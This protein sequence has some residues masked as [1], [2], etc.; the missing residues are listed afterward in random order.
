MLT[1][2]LWWAALLLL[3]LNDHVLKGAGLLDPSITGKLSDVVGLFLAP[4]LFA[5]LLRQ[6][7]RRGLLLT[8]LAIGAAFAAIN[9]SEHAANGLVASMG[10]LGIH[11][12]IWSDPT[13]LLTL[14]VLFVSWR[15]IQRELAE[16]QA[17]SLRRRFMQGLACALGATFCL[18]TSAAPAPHTRVSGQPEHMRAD[19]FL[20]NDAAPSVSVHIS[21]L[22]DH[23]D[24]NCDDALAQP[25]SVF[26]SEMF[27]RE[28]LWHQQS[29]EAAALWP[30]AARN[31][32]TQE[33]ECGAIIFRVDD[34]ESILAVWKHS[35]L[36]LKPVPIIP[37]KDNYPDGTILV[38]K[39]GQRFVMSAKGPVTLVSWP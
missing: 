20:V 22:S 3:A 28:G 37:P 27:I 14:P 31:A 38:Q 18:A 17:L 8:H 36:P 12:Q 25:L 29:G 30:I 9:L 33:R 11:W 4:A 13:D 39:E 16:A 1:H 19:V 32:R 2:P 23:A 15:F 10:A 7:T 35:E 21:M 24:F 5:T 34:S 26:K 6:H